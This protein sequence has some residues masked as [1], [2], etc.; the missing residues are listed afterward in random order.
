M[1]GP[2]HGDDQVLV[3]VQMRFPTVDRRVIAEHIAPMVT[4]A[5]AA[6]GE[7]T[8]ISVQGY[9]DEEADEDG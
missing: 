9:T 3:T 7:Y 5:I 2:D 4:A 8:S 6:G 1:T